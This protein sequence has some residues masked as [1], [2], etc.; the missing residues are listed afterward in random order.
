MLVL[1]SLGLAAV[2]HAVFNIL[3]FA[4]L[5]LPL[6]AVVLTIGGAIWVFSRFK[7][8]QRISPFRYRRNYPEVA[9]P[10]CGRLIRIMSR[11]CRFCGAPAASE[12]GRLF[13]GHC[14]AGNRPDAGYCTSCG[15]RLLLT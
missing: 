8:G 10:S 14:G 6:G 5:P 3:A 1:A 7:W 13:C 9:C 2:A 12:A 4:P 15:D 11:F